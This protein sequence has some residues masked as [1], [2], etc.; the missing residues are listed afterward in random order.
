L[1]R[2]VNLLV[3]SDLPARLLA[4]LE[5]SGMKYD[6]WCSD[7][8]VAFPGWGV[9]AA[10]TRL[11]RVQLLQSGSATTLALHESELLDWVIQLSEGNTHLLESF[12]ANYIGTLESG[13]RWRKEVLDWLFDKLGQPSRKRLTGAWRRIDD[14]R[15]GVVAAILRWLALLKMEDFFREANDPHGRFEFW[16][17]HFSEHIIRATPVARG[18]A[19]LLHMPPLAIVEFSEKGN[20]AYVYP[21][22]E[23]SR[24]VSRRNEPLA[25]YKDRDR[26]LR[27][28]RN[29]EGYRI[30]HNAGWQSANVGVLRRMVG[31][32]R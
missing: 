7:I 30:L 13:H 10:L 15:P 2:C 12:A 29:E 20:A 3:G 8:D 27:R 1:E 18:E 21:E 5:S 17:E 31:S 4:D 25:H 11:V 14:I 28:S 23:H 32:M 6:R 9:S 19:I 24:L 22:S 26:L 16:R